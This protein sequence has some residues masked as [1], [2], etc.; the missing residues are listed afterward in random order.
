MVSF[1]K[2]TLF[3]SRNNAHQSGHFLVEMIISLAILLTVLATVLP[4]WVKM[5]ERDVHLQMKEL[6]I[7]VIQ[8]ELQLFQSGEKSDTLSGVHIRTLQDY[9]YIVRW[10]I[11]EKNS[12]A[13]I[14]EE[15]RVEVVWLRPDYQLENIQLTALRMKGATQ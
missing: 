14:I 13:Y 3:S 15:G 6:G 2:K 4:I 9:S 11:S 10:N 8:N 5:Q 7:T 1:V 12:G